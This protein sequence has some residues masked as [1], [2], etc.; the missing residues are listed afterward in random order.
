MEA[1]EL[2]IGN[3]VYTRNSYSEIGN[4]REIGNYYEFEPIKL[5]DEIKEKCNLKDCDN[6]YYKYL[7]LSENKY[8]IISRKNIVYLSDCNGLYDMYVEINELEF[9][10]QLQNL[11]YALTGQELEIN[12]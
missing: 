7:K 6:S 2:R 1:N 4:S 5:T 10:H 9:L 11:Y 12:L 8:L 3:F